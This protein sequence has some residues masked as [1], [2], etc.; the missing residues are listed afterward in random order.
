MKA[1]FQCLG[2]DRERLWRHT[3]SGQRAPG[4][5]AVGPSLSRTPPPNELGLG[6]FQQD[7]CISYVLSNFIWR[8]FGAGWLDLAA[9]GRLGGLALQATTALSRVTFGRESHLAQLEKKGHALHGVCLRALAGELSKDPVTLAARAPGLMAS[10]LVLLVHANANTDRVETV[11]HIKG[12]SGLLHLVGPKGCQ[13]QPLL[14]MFEAFR[15]P[16][17]SIHRPLPPPPVLEPRPRFSHKPHPALRTLINNHWTSADRRF[18]P[19]APTA[20]PR[21]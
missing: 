14:S 16:V 13:R 7:F 11:S 20:L 4:N 2:Y 21:A 9:Q 6:A 15:G 1:G 12:L 17:V 3:F 10:S 18:S 19:H 8:A 5:S